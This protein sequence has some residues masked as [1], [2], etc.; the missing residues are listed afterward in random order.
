MMRLLKTGFLLVVMMATG[1]AV[2]PLVQAHAGIPASLELRLG[3]AKV[4]ITPAPGTPL[5]G[6]GKRRGKGSTGVHDPLY[7]R[8]VS[9]QTE[10]RIFVFISCDLVLI[11]ENLRKRVLKIIEEKK[12][13]AGE[14]LLLTATHTHS[15]AGA[16]GSRL[17]EKFIMGKFRP[18][19]FEKITREIAR[20]ALLSMEKAVP[21]AL[22]YGERE[23]DSLVENRLDEKLDAPK[24]L[25]VLRFK[26][27]DGKIL[28]HFI[29]MAA[30]P[31]I[32]SAQN[33]EFSADFPGVINQTL[34][35]QSPG[36][37]SLFLNGAAGDLRPKANAFGTPDMLDGSR[38]E[39]MT[40]YGQAIADE[41][42]KISFSN[43]ELNGAFGAVL[44][45]IKLPRV[46][47][48]A[49]KFPVPSLL[50]G[51]IFPRAS[52]FQALRL[53]PFLF[54]AFPGELGSETGWEIERLARSRLFIPFVI[55][56]ANDYTGYVIPERY[57]RD[58]R[59]Y[60][61]RASFYGP[62]WDW[63]I[64]KQ[65]LVLMDRLISEDEKSKIFPAG[66]LEKR[67]LSFPHGFRRESAQTDPRQKHSG[68]TESL[69][70]LKLEGDPY[71]LGFEEGRLLQKEIREGLEDISRYFRK[72]LPVPI[73][74]RAGIHFL[75]D[76]AWKKMEPFISYA[77]YLQMK[78]LADGAGIPLKKIRRLHALPELY[79][80]FCANGA[81]WGKAT[82]GG[83]LIALRNLDWNRKIG[84]QRRAA[85]KFIHEPG[86]HRY[87]NI[88]YAGFTGVLSG[89][90]E[91]GIS[92]G[93]I[94][95][96]SADESMAGVPMPFLLKRL[97]EESGSL[98]E[99]AGIFKR[100]EL[101]RGYNYVIADASAP[102]AMA[103]E[104]THR[105][106]AFF[107]DQDPAE[108]KVTYACP[109]ENAVL[110]AD[111]A[112]DPAIRNLQW[113]SQGNPKK[114]GPE[115]P[116]GGAYEI[117]Y[118]KQAELVQESYGKITPET[119]KQIAREI[120]PG[121]NI[122]SVIYT[123]PEFWVANAKEDE[124]AAESGYVEFS[125]EKDAS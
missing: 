90:N 105:H 22:E 79:P 10:N 30:H 100:S 32:L 88:G 1:S 83:R 115:P 106:L 48:R 77:E 122:Q 117:R 42:S 68:M 98:E 12:P 58:S 95:S 103:V 31:T 107:R 47:A 74:N 78:G 116:A 94:G 46:K 102:G 15:G 119:V 66:R 87:V 60:E 69:P 35:E 34:E 56:Y 37:V 38:F 28:A 50:G 91:K 121:S 97:L 109:L 59:Q 21:V 93:Q 86:N 52:S 81:Y 96:T 63:F 85:V 29:F 113:A 55:G 36:S 118:K 75:L 73:L 112:M 99:A 45:K 54:M 39:K 23:I 114:A 53:G 11:D 111:T 89:M 82:A 108:S 4:E 61:S 62:K 3:A 7:A 13:L 76:R 40:A 24:T 16:I 9:L 33:L 65:A 84:I 80:T 125:F 110:R 57:Y 17:W 92:V 25:K 2:T 8:A 19:V 41:I 101:T 18:P 6:F 67:L 71:H 26:T 43:I 14:N 20:A 120:A 51:R 64:Q 70:V 124:K 27:E 123:F 44:L 49:G 104:A 5:A 72:E